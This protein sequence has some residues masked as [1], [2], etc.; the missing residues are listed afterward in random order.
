M[1]RQAALALSADR[2][3]EAERIAKEALADSSRNG[4]ALHILG[5]ALLMQGRAKEAIA[6]LETALRGRHD[7]KIET[8][9]AMA[10]RFAGR[11]DE[12]AA[13]LKRFCKRGPPY[14]P[15]F[16]ELGVVLSSI[17]RH[18]E[19]IEVLRRG[20][21]IAPMMPQLSI[22]RGYAFLG[23]W[24]PSNAKAE[25][26]RALEIL[27]GS[28]DALLGM[29]R[30]QRESGD[31]QAA[32]EHIR[33]C[34]VNNPNEAWAWNLLGHCLLELGQLDAGYDCFRTAGRRHPR[35][36]GQALTSLVT[37]RR[38][39]LWLRPSAAQ[40]FFARAERQTPSTQR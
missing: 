32:V 36:W 16:L 29:A 11:P 24:D 21:D 39:R 23:S 14:A 35:G 13:R 40:Q 1:L 6:P 31:A 18:Q 30:A 37:S 12:A 26:A 10:L 25:F 19:A 34:L 28:S 2:P 15:A 17:G 22:A 27:P 4:Q 3:R 8:Q 5:C 7:P 33:R 20:L 9:L 38:G